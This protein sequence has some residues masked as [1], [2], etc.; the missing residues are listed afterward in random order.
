[1]WL[2]PSPRL[3]SRV[4]L[5]SST[6]AVRRGLT[7]FQPV[8][9]RLQFVTS[10][11]GVDFVDDSKA[12]NS[13]AT[14]VA[15]ATFDQVVW[16]A[17][18][19]AKGGRFDDLV[20]RHRDRLVGVVLMGTDRGVIHDAIR[21][22]APQ[23]PVIEVA[24]GETDPMEIAVRHATALATAGCTVLLSPGCAS[25]DQFADYAARGAAFQSAVR[26]LSL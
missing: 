26:R 2:T 17:G 24:D 23:V 16:I 21:R 6:S 5:V 3:L 20:L 14:E 22:H 19:L 4:R 25:M 12:T 7:G 1:M 15:L 11:A 10:H 9:H 13:H 18:G 8:D